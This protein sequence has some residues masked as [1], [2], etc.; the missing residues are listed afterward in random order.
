MLIVEHTVTPDTPI[1]IDGLGDSGTIKVKSISKNLLK[2]SQVEEGT[3]NGLTVTRDYDNDYVILNGTTTGVVDINTYNHWG[4]NSHHGTYIQSNNLG[5]PNWWYD[6]TSYTTNTITTSD[7]R[8]ATKSFIRVEKGKTFNNAILKIQ[9]EKGTTAT[10]WQPYT[11]TQAL[12]PISAPLYD[13]DYIEVFA[14]GTGKIVRN[15]NICNVTR[16]REFYNPLTISKE[17]DFYVPSDCKKSGKLYCNIAKQKN[18]TTW[19]DDRVGIMNYGGNGT[20]FRVRIPVSATNTD[21]PCSILYEL[22]TPTTEPLTAEQISEF[23]KLQTFKGVTH[24]NA[25]GEVTV[26]YYC[27]N[28]SGETVS[29]VHDIAN[30]PTPTFTEATTR[31][32]IESGEKLSAIMGKIKKLFTDLKAVAFSGSY[33]DLSNKPTIP[34]LANN[35][36]TTSS[37]MALDARQ[38]KALNDKISTIN[39]NL[40]TINS[41]LNGITSKLS[42]IED[43]ANKTIVDSALSNS[44]TN[45][46][47]NKVVNSAIYNLTSRLIPYGDVNI[48]FQLGATSHQGTY[49]SAS[50]Y[51]PRNTTI[52]FS[53]AG[54]L[55]SDG[56]F[57]GSI[58]FNYSGNYLF[59]TTTNTNLAGRTVSC[60][61]TV[62]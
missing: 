7:T 5:L 34:S 25:D 45:P 4:L 31:E 17:A 26:R 10:E 20:S 48:I 55:G 18:G 23:K 28:D 62:S 59:I 3:R 9:V 43:G 35:L 44:S 19:N 47:Q 51:V 30:N 53:S 50:V 39:S 60:V 54:V 58:N 49:Y 56:N 41:N 11:E 37:G 24:V 12:I 29:M 27:N 33:T 36:T 22:A 61:G 2:V 13:G 42:N 46:V 15:W 1:H 32:N 16:W 21:Y 52:T 38:G 57:I 6:G 14:D 40:G 8:Q